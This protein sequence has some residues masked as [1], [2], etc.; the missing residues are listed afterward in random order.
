MFH[1]N[2]VCANTPREQD[3]VTDVFLLLGNGDDA[4]GCRLHAENEYGPL[5]LRDY[6]IISTAVRLYR[7]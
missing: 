1:I 4:V 5:T 7:E 6:D 2:T 3:I